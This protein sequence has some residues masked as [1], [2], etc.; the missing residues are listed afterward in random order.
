MKENLKEENELKGK[1]IAIQQKLLEIAVQMFQEKKDE[2]EELKTANVQHNEIEFAQKERI[3]WQEQQL[4]SLRQ[5]KSSLL[6]ANKNLQESRN[7]F[8]ERIE[9]LNKE[10]R[11]LKGGKDNG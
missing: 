6:E 5:S 2:C 4:E 3:E 10:L 11:K 1:V 9:E 7:E 8:A